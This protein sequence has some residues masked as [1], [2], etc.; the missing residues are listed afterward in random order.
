MRFAGKRAIVTGAAKGIGAAIASRLAAE[1]AEVVVA[2]VNEEL[3]AETAAGLRGRFVRLDVGEETQ[4]S[5]LER[6]V[7]SL[8][9]LVNNAG[10]NPGPV[11]FEDAT[12]DHWR[13]VHSINL[14]GVFLGCRMAL[15]AMA[16]R[17]GVIVNVGSAAGTRPVGEMAAY[18]SSK[19][20]VHMLTRAVALYAGRRGLNV[21]CNAVAP[22]SVETPLVERLRSATGDA[23]AARARSAALHPIGH[24]GA[25]DD[26]ADAVAFLASD[27]AR[28]VTGAV[29]AVD[30]GLSI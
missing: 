28:F 27:E 13:R 25:P 8:D 18:S 24:V 5:A 3:G 22:G 9:I 2:D 16:G 30:G 21:R 7:G 14:D 12:L 4:W 1:G 20:A 17:G 6:S 11:A 10:I 26:I 29:F 19:A 15:R 23:A